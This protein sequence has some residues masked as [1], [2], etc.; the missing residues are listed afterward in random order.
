M[1][2]GTKGEILFSSSL[3]CLLFMLDPCSSFTRFLELSRWLM[4]VLP[5]WNELQM[6]GVNILFHLA[7]H[8]GRYQRSPGCPVWSPALHIIFQPIS[9]VP[10]PDVHQTYSSFIQ[11]SVSLTV[12]TKALYKMMLEASLNGETWDVW[13]PCSL[14][15][16]P[17]RRLMRFVPD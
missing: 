11:T 15:P 17:W 14:L 7:C 6:Q 9:T 1:C 12:T 5:V 2:C 13:Q 16:C 4:V 10:Q 3:N 8:W